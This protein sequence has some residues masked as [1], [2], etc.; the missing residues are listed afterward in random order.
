MG[1][2]MEDP[3]VGFHQMITDPNILF[4]SC[5][6]IC[7]ILFF[8]LNGLVLTKHVSCM[9]RAFWDATRTVSVWMVSLLI[10]LE[11]FEMKSFVIQFAG[12]VCLVL[13][14]FTYNEII[15]W[16]ICGINSHMSKYLDDDGNLIKKSKSKKPVDT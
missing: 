15:E 13:G 8:N 6:I 9:F 11:T 1:G 16:K 12:F 3:V 10:G 14:N 4:W 2:Y 7:S 5:V